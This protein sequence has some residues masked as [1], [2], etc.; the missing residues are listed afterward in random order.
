MEDILVGRMDALKR[1]DVERMSRCQI[2][3]SKQ[4]QQLWSQ[5]LCESK[6]D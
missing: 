4:M 5:A 3:T 1:V 2:A 6:R